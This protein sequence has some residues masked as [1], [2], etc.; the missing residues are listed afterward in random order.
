VA[1]VGAGCRFTDRCPRAD[2]ACRAAEPACLEI[3]PGHAVAC[4]KAGA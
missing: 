2:A 4:F 1:D 3:A